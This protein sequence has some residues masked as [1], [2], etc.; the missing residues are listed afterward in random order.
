MI[1]RLTWPA[2]E[3]FA[4]AWRNLLISAAGAILN[5]LSF[6][7]VAYLFGAT[8]Q[9][10]I[11]LF[12]LSFVIVVSALITT[13]FSAIFLPLY[14]K[15]LHQPDGAVQA[16]NFACSFFARLLVLAVL[17]GLCMLIAPVPIFSWV[18]KFDPA[19]LAQ[20]Q[21]LLTYFSLVFSLT[22]V[23]E[24]FRVILLAHEGYVAASSSVLL[25][26]LSN[27]ALMAVLAVL[28]GVHGLAVAAAASRCIQCVYLLWRMCRIGVRIRLHLASNSYL[29]EF[30]RLAGSY[31]A[32]SIISTISVFFYDYVASGLPAGQLT[33]V[34]FA[35]KIYM[36]PVSMLAL[37]V[38]EI[39][40]TKLS[41]LHARKESEAVQRLYLQSLTLSL[42]VMLP[43]SLII[44]L[45]AFPISEILL[46]RGAYS[47]SSLAIT[48]HSMSILA[49]A[50]PW[51]VVFAINGRI[52]LVFQNT[53]VPSLFGSLG[54]LMSIF[55]VWWLVHALGYIGL[56][57]AKLTMEILYFLPFGFL[58][59]RY[60][61]SLR[62]KTLFGDLAKI[63]MAAVLAYVLAGCGISFMQH[64]AV[65][66]LIVLLCSS[67]LL[68][69]VFFGLCGF[70]GVMVHG[71][72][73]SLRRVPKPKL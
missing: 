30:R 51:I 62:W 3:M 38:I 6:V 64:A 5:Y 73:D 66:D 45:N 65:P 68:L 36:L 19:I 12:A 22:V 1:R 44:S 2:G 17:V 56:A 32:A 35:Q 33:A 20:N 39:L 42:L 21:G 11:F 27:L 4:A 8:A 59:V 31:W 63:G 61:I 41:T 60:S 24:F 25:Q 7:I 28:W 58:V 34:A 49:L 9:T 14:I 26:T 71:L 53:S 37:P 69:V 13:V 10:D 16:G 18:S 48:V 67:V 54:H 23:N 55:V 50:I 72:F 15:L 43:I 52:S 57:W 46:S 40:N 70:S 47:Q 29:G